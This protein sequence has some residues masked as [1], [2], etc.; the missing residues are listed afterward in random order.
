MMSGSFARSRADA[1]AAR[2]AQGRLRGRVSAIAVILP[3]SWRTPKTRRFRR[4]DR[5]ARAAE[6][7]AVEVAELERPDLAGE[8]FLDRL[9]RNAKLA[10]ELGLRDAFLDERLHEVP[11][12][13]CK[14]PRHARVLDRLGS[15]LLDPD[16][17]VCVPGWNLVFVHVLSMT[18]SGCRVNRLLSL[19]SALRPLVTARPRHSTWITGIH[20]PRRSRGVSY[21]S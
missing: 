21:G 13:G 1:P 10:G 11:T 18:T 16:E 2:V 3:G 15:H 6:A 20:G 12:H 17:P 4:T 7:I 9:A 5:A 8:H 19:L 14:L